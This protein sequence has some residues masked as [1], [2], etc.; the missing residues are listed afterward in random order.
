MFIRMKYWDYSKFAFIFLIT[1]LCNDDDV[2]CLRPL[3]SLKKG[4]IFAKVFSCEFYEIFKNIFFTE[5]LRTI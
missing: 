2:G 3:T 4:E 5:H 1:N